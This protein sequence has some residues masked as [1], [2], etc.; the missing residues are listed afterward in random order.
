MPQPALQLTGIIR[1]DGHGELRGHGR[2]DRFAGISPDDIRTLVMEHAIREASERDEQ[3]ELRV[4][5]VD[6]VFP[7]LIA[8]DGT[9]N[10]NGPAEPL[11]FGDDQLSPPDAHT[12]YS[13]TLHESIRI[14]R[15]EMMSAIPDP[16]RKPDAKP[17]PKSTR[18]QKADGGATS[19]SDSSSTAGSGADQQPADE[20]P[21]QADAQL[22]MHESWLPSF[23]RDR[24]ADEQTGDS[25]ESPRDAVQREIDAIEQAVASKSAN[26]EQKTERV[27]AD[28]APAQTGDGNGGLN[29]DTDPRPAGSTALGSNAS[30]IPPMPGADAQ[31]ATAQ[32]QNQ[33]GT[34]DASPATGGW[35][36]VAGRNASGPGAMGKAPRDSATPYGPVPSIV[37]QT[38]P[39]GAAVAPK[40]GSSAPAAPARPEQAE[41]PTS[42]PNLAA[43][44]APDEVNAAQSK[45]EPAET[46]DPAPS[47]RPESN[48]SAPKPEPNPRAPKPEPNPPAPNPEPDAEQRPRFEIPQIPEERPKP[49]A[50]RVQAKPGTGT[51][52]GGVPTLDDFLRDGSPMDERPAEQG[53]RAG[54]RRGTG[55]LISLSPS[56]R[57]RQERMEIAS[58]QRPL[59]G[60]RTIVVVNPKGGAHKTTA[61][62]MIAAMFGIYRGGYTLAW[63]NNE[64]RGTL[65]WRSKPGVHRNTAVDLLRQLPHF[66]ISGGTAIGDIDRF[67]RNQGEARFDVLASDDDAASAAII[68]D[69]A[70]SRLHSTLSR[71][72]RVLVVDTGN[73]MRAS[74]WEAALDSADQLVIVSTHREDTAAS[75]AWLAD[76]L[77][78]R[79]HAD[80]LANAVTILSSPSAKEDRELTGRLVNHFQQLTRAVVQVPYDEKFVGG[81]ELDV[82]RLSPR[83]RLAW[84]HAAAV[85]AEG[86]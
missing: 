71:F 50:R 46:P 19:D 21:Q 26:A 28:T 1:E 8:P 13:M 32:S 75:A 62:L 12:G 59:S 39:G 54:L 33:T 82:M 24:D 78:E 76:G 27:G 63:D 9:I 16:E 2:V 64:T 55:G 17:E 41:A 36:Q 79:G 47:P 51:G 74:N 18:G 70:F 80:K 11:Q 81:G 3:I 68:D 69:E 35:H 10:E 14:P 42:A 43:S 4:V 38:G 5:D 72:Y 83:T 7:L 6:G 20:K 44:T 58:I 67:V 45:R 66:E 52:T 37:R 86:L 60:S 22:D 85:I 61:T 23:P 31:I 15:G 57:E 84:R 29:E 53:W 65:G 73:N 56:A 48:A 34:Q 30:K 77:R 25:S 40:P 49:A